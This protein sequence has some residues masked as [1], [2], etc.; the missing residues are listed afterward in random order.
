[1]IKIEID[2]E[3]TMG[4]IQ[5]PTAFVYGEMG[6]VIGLFYETLCEHLPAEMATKLL[7]ACVDGA[8]MTEEEMSE[9]LEEFKTKDPYTHKLAEAIT[10]EY[11]VGESRE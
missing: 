10:E 7:H 4:K 2:R 5:G 3:K 9:K 8:A 11:L 6:R 1:M